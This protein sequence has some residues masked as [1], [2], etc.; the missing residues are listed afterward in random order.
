M[1]KKIN[2]ISFN[3]YSSP[4]HDFYLQHGWVVLKPQL[5]PTEL[6]EIKAGWL[7]MIQS[8]AA[9]IGCDYALYR[10]QI[11]QWRDLWKHHS[12]FHKLLNNP[13]LWKTAAHSFEQENVRLLHDHIICKTPQAGNG[14]IP[15]HQDSMFWPVDRTGTSTWMPLDDVSLESGCLEVIDSSHL[16]GGHSPVDFMSP[17]FEVSENNVV[18]QIPAKAG[19][20]VLLHSLTWHRSAPNR[21]NVT[22]PA[23][24]VLWVASETRFAP[25]KA[26]WHPILEHIEVEKNNVLNDNWFPF[27]GT[28]K[29]GTGISFSNNHSGITQQKQGI[30]MFGARKKV[31]TQI[32]ALL[33]KKGTLSELLSDQKI[34]AVLSNKILASAQNNDITLSEISDVVDAVWLSATAYERHRSRNVFNSAYA[35]WWALMEK[36]PKS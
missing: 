29:Q 7:E 4:A 35:Q 20:I 12:V 23:H 17:C 3:Q 1:T 27:F 31:Q 9:E 15:W 28:G 26:D 30:S 36:L 10:R 19:S 22:R 25:E 32:E 11:S 16:S 14:E 8:F 18:Y 24:I 34:R 2:T 5:T 21:S 6:N 33:A 13:I